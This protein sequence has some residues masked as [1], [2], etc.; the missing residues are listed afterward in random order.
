[1][2]SAVGLCGKIN[3]DIEFPKDD[4]GRTN[5]SSNPAW[6]YLETPP[7][8]VELE[9]FLKFTNIYFDGAPPNEEDKENIL[10]YLVWKRKR[11]RKKGKGKQ[12][13]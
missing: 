12:G 8:N 1:M 6:W 7:T 3:I 5:D 10:D 2:F 11:E 9:E 13:W 4:P